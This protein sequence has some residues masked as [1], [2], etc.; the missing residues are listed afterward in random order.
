MKEQENKERM[1]HLLE[2]T[3]FIQKQNDIFLTQEQENK[4]EQQKREKQKERR[5]EIVL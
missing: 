3:K 4:S 1:R 2:K 5:K